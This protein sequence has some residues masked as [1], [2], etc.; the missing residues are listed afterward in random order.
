M[1][2][3]DDPD[4]SG[5]FFIHRNTFALLARC[6]VWED[7]D[8]KGSGSAKPEA[9]DLQAMAVLPSNFIWRT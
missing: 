2:P 5:G 6:G 4:E 8:I 9:L 1:V 3:E 7:G